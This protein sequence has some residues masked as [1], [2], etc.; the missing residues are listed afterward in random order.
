MAGISTSRSFVYISVI[1]MSIAEYPL[2]LPFASKK[3]STDWE[4]KIFLHRAPLSLRMD[5]FWF[6]FPTTK[7]QGPIIIRNE[8]LSRL[9]CLKLTAS[10]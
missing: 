5:Q 9:D 8:T 6:N 7:G 4:C 10:Q 2:L 3:M 1:M